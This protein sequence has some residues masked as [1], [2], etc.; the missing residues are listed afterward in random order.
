[1]AAAV[2]NSVDATRWPCLATPFYIGDGLAVGLH[3][4]G[5]FVGLIFVNGTGAGI[6]FA[7]AMV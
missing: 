1:M 5:H 4:I 2:E 3:G 6:L 7:A